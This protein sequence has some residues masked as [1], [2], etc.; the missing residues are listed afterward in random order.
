ML[1]YLDRPLIHHFQNQ[2]Q[3]SIIELLSKLRD[4]RVLLQKLHQPPPNL[5]LICLTSLT[6][7]KWNFPL[8]FR[9][10]CKLSDLYSGI[11]QNSLMCAKW[12]FP[13]NFHTMRKLSDLYSGIFQTQSSGCASGV[14]LFRNFTKLKILNIWIV[15]YLLNCK[16]YL[17]YNFQKNFRMLS[18]RE[19]GCASGTDHFRTWILKFSTCFFTVFRTYWNFNMLFY[20]FQHSFSI[21]F[22]HALQISTCSEIF[23]TLSNIKIW[24]IYSQIVTEPIP[25]YSKS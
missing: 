15:K 7:A 25:K 8:N 19:S 12:N 4:Y 1:F 11:F 3:F 21:W 9:T 17:S 14:D 18:T 16:R 5:F 13:L 24:N 20:S 6:R 10:M 22:Q 23:N 2:Y